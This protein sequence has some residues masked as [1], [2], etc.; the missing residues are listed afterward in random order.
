[1]PCAS[2]SVSAREKKKA[3]GYVHNTKVKG[4]GLCTTRKHK[5]TTEMA[6]S[7]IG[8]GNLDCYLDLRV[9]G[10]AGHG[11]RMGEERL[12]KIMRDS[13]LDLPQKTGRPTRSHADQMRGGLKRK[14]MPMGAWK[15]ITANRTE[16]KKAIRAP[17][18]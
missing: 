18:I 7:K 6:H 11:E 4:T 16:W 13:F 12:P 10:H 3:R 14:Q 2:T 9:L 1:V 17:S 15:T 5:I 8:V